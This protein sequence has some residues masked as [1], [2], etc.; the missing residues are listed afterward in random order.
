MVKIHVPISM[1]SPEA[2]QDKTKNVSEFH[3][4]RRGRLELGGEGLKHLR[5]FL[6]ADSTGLLSAGTAAK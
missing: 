3:V 1:D 5:Q 6:R 4:L 2:N